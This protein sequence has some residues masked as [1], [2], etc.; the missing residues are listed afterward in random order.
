MSFATLASPC[1]GKKLTISHAADV[2]NSEPG[3]IIHTSP[4]AQ[5]L[6]ASILRLRTYQ[7]IGCGC[8][9]WTGVRDL[10]I[11]GLSAYSASKAALNIFGQCLAKEE[12]EAMVISFDPGTVD[13]AMHSFI[14]AEGQPAMLP[15]DYAMFVGLHEQ[16]HLRLP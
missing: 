6:D 15:A 2:A 4:R 3:A 14:R 12:P 5:H 11:S 10:P 7:W 1:A 9:A 16:G 13:T 8:R